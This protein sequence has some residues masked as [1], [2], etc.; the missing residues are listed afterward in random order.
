VDGY[1]S[2]MVGPGRHDG[3]MGPLEA[4]A[5]ERAI[6][7]CLSDYCRGIERPHSSV[8]SSGSD[9]ARS[10]AV[11]GHSGERGP[12]AATKV[13]SSGEGRASGWGSSWRKF[14]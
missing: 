6:R 3:G 12:S 2:R 9:H 13:V 5:A 14:P 4:A 10:V 11:H 7:R 1:G 8:V